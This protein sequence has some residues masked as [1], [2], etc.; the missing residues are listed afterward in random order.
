MKNQRMTNNMNQEKDIRWRQRFQNFEKAYTVLDKTMKI[1]SPSE[2][3]IMAVIQAFELSF[4]LAWKVMTDYLESEGFDPKSPRE[5]IKH[6]FQV[7]LVEDGHVWM[8]ALKDRNLIMHT[9]DEA[10]AKEMGLKIKN[11]YYPAIK[12]LYVK[13]KEWL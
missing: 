7:K 1:I 3:E 4:E 13:M 10:F 8:D 11:N 9:Y 2:I 5:T 6:A 12:C